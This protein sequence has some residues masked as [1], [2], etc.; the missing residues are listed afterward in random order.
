MTDAW[1]I[2]G[3]PGAGKTTLARHLAERLERSAAIEG[4][5]LQGWIV[6]GNVWPGTEPAAEATRQIRLN[7]KNQ[8][9]L[10]R[11]Y[12]GA[13]FTPVI[14]YVIV[15]RADLD[16]YRRGLEGLSL[17]LVVLH[18]GKDVVIAREASREKS[19]RHR[20]K[21]G[22]TIGE[23]YAHLEAPMVEELTGIGFWIDTA[24]LPP[25]AIADEI[26]ANR[27]RALLA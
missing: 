16:E 3:I 19:Q 12:A 17:H 2:T 20:A 18:P 26:L 15:T 7:M 23:H 22:H 9:L 4:D 10:A 14:D 5:L 8:C 21:H 11:S 24:A 27:S 6:S 13:G 25:A 1:L